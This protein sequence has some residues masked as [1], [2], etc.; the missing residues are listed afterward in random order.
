MV[1]MSTIANAQTPDWTWAKN[2]SMYLNTKLNMTSIDNEGNVY[3][4]G[5]CNAPIATMAV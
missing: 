5:D 4:V 2:I 1:F 3:L